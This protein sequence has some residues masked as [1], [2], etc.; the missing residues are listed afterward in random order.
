LS[1]FLKITALFTFTGRVSVRREASDVASSEE[2][3]ASAIAEEQDAADGCLVA[4]RKLTEKV[5]NAKITLPLFIIPKS[6]F[7]NH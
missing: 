4:H 3:I 2:A 1:P 7:M 5:N 6:E